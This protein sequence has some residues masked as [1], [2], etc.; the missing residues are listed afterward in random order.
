MQL[1]FEFHMIEA[2]PNVLIDDRACDSDTLDDDMRGNGVKMVSPRRKNRKTPKTQ[3][4]QK[5]RR[6]KRR[7]TVD[8]FFAW[9]KHKR[10]LLNR[11]ELYPGSFL[12]FA[13]VSA[14]ILVP[15]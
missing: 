5:L 13:Q 2:M 7:W 14:A 12:G 3:D 10:R 4:G 8:R 11:W 6:Y 1:S 9:M 15:R